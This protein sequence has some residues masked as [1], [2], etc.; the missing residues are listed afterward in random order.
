[1]I[2]MEIFHEEKVHSEGIQEAISSLKISCVTM[3]M[4]IKD[5]KSSTDN[6]N[7]TK[8]AMRTVIHI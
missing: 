2:N 1:M 8:D 3:C 7:M 6:D 5:K 4:R